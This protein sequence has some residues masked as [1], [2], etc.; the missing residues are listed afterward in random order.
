MR[1]GRFLEYLQEW[2]EKACVLTVHVPTAGEPLRLGGVLRSYYSLNSIRGWV[3][4]P[5]VQH[6]GFET[7][8][9][10]HLTFDEAQARECIDGPHG[11]VLRYSADGR[12]VFELERDATAFTAPP[13]AVK[14]TRYLYPGGR[15]R[16]RPER[17]MT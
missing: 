1:L 3:L 2:S 5:P 14:T 12:T 17:W 13:R 11:P 7:I 8:R 16:R 6:G 9:M 4:V 15:R 10:T